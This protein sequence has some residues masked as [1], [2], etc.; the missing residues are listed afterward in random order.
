MDTGKVA[1][2]DIPA[3]QLLDPVALTAGVDGLAW[4][5]SK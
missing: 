1:V 2:V 5:P 4:I 3:W